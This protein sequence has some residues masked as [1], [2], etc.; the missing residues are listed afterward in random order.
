[1]FVGCL[2]GIQ[3]TT[4]CFL[5]Y[6]TH[7]EHAPQAHEYQ[8]DYSRLVGM[9]VCRISHVDSGILLERLSSR[10]QTRMATGK[11]QRHTP[12]VIILEEQSWDCG[13]LYI[14][15]KVS[16]GNKRKATSL[17]GP[18]LG[19][20]PVWRFL[21]EWSTCRTSVVCLRGPG[22]DQRTAGTGRDTPQLLHP[23]RALPFRTVYFASSKNCSL[24]DFGLW[25]SPYVRLVSYAGSPGCFR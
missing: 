8:P 19:D 3:N 6:R 16:K 1:M 15:I 17:K 21:G 18:L 23:F 5:H 2:K 9:R 12:N 7:P 25:G 22:G 4:H 24:A 14:R 11:Q 10:L 20:Q 13:Y